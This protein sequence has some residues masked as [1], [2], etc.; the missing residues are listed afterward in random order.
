VV[1]YHDE[2]QA[3]FKVPGLTTERVDKFSV[4]RQL[5]RMA[6]E[7]LRSPGKRFPEGVLPMTLVR[8]GTTRML[9]REPS[10]L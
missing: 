4:G 1:G 9:V 3:Q 10:V 2:D 6:I 7:K 8:R 5:A